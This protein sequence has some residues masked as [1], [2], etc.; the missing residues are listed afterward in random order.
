[1][2]DKTTNTCKHVNLEYPRYVTSTGERKQAVKC[3]DCQTILW[4]TDG[5]GDEE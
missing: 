1:M 2:D 4:I 5:G 3:I